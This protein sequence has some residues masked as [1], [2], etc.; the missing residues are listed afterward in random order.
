M[1]NII[2]KSIANKWHI[3]IA[4]KHSNEHYNGIIMGETAGFLILKEYFDFY[5]H[6]LQIFSKKAI[7]GLRDDDHETIANKLIRNNGEILRG[8][9]PSW[10]SHVSNYYSLFNQIKQRNIW[11]A[12]EIFRNSK[13]TEFY[14]G[15]ITRVYR[16]HFSLLF[17]DSKGNWESE[18]RLKYSSIYRVIIRD[19]YTETFNQYMRKFNPKPNSKRT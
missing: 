15:Q 18:Y 12:V 10:L 11:P 8:N 7:K 5:Y 17:Y 14:L 4:A 16:N 13:K 19:K 9:Y 3:Q 6:G 2:R 1:K